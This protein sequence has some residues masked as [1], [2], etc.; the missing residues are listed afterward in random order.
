MSWHSN[1][2]LI[3][4]LYIAF[5]GRPADPGGLK[6][7]ASQL[8]DNAQPNSSEVRNLIQAFIN[9]P[10]A[11]ARFGD[12][13]LQYVIDRIYTFAFHRDATDADKAKYVGKTVVDVLIDV[14]SQTI[15]EDAQT[16]S[17][18]LIYAK[19]FTQYLDPNLDGEPN[20][21]ST[22]QKFVANFY[23]NTDATAI[24]SKL[25]FIKFDS[26]FKNKEVFN[27]LQLIADPGD[28]YFSTTQAELDQR[29][30]QAIKSI[31]KSSSS[32]GKGGSEEFGVSFYYNTLSIPFSGS[33][34]ELYY[35]WVKDIEKSYIDLDGSKP[36]YIKIL[37]LVEN[38]DLS[39][40]DFWVV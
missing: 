37:T 28:Y 5:Y 9:S 15:G 14:I 36:E 30:S 19:A 22:G 8:P 17:N 34:K 26:I 38:S 31:I 4:K 7:W 35:E 32:D 6:Y 2:D 40:T 21:D 25:F 20:D 18:K 13:E 33:D 29:I 23:G 10:E 39:I 16:F 3:Q 11:K 24:T 12:P 1:V 27:D